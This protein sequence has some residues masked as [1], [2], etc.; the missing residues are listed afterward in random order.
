MK[1]ITIVLAMEARESDV[2]TKTDILKVPRVWV[3]VCVCVCV[4]A[5]VRVLERETRARGTRA[6]GERVTDVEYQSCTH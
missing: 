3:C 4:C 5:C 1:Q 6:Q 2:Q